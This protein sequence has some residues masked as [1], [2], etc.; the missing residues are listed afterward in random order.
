MDILF[1]ESCSCALCGRILKSYDKYYLCEQ[2]KGNLIFLE[3]PKIVLREL[4][5]NKLLLNTEGSGLKLAL[6]V[7]AYQGLSREMVHKL[8]YN[9]KIEIA[10]SMALYISEMLQKNSTKFDIIVPVPSHEKRIKQRGYNQAYLIAE[11]LSELMNIPCCDMLQKVKDTKSQVL[12]NGDDR[13]Y[14]VKD[15][16][17]LNTNTKKIKLKGLKVLLVDDIITTG[18]TVFYCSCELEK[19]GA[20]DVTAVSFART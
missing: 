15:A 13:W 17:A 5:N 2:C 19:N 8:K 1:P 16:F 14:N 10:S 9:G 11:K 20:K 6:S 12:L 3:S 18:A 7:F 4:Y